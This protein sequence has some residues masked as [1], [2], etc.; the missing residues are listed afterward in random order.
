MGN[1]KGPFL[2]DFGSQIRGKGPRCKIFV[3]LGVRLGMKLESFVGAQSVSYKENLC[4]LLL[5]VPVKKGAGQHIPTNRTKRSAGT[6]VDGGLSTANR[7]MPDTMGLT[8]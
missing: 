5:G 7:R 1:T 4:E 8:K 6:G 2:E 3:G